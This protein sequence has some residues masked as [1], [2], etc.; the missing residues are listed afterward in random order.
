MMEL[1]FLEIQSNQVPECDTLMSRTTCIHA[2][3]TRKGYSHC[4][5]RGQCQKLQLINGATPSVS[6]LLPGAH[7]H[8]P[9][10]RRIS[11]PSAV[12]PCSFTTSCLSST[13]ELGLTATNEHRADSMLASHTQRSKI[14]QFHRER[15][16]VARPVAAVCQISRLQSNADGRSKIN[17][18]R[19]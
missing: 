9:S 7:L 10:R 8:S 18:N 4:G 13:T 17:Q 14:L 2:I 15:H 11:C 3:L 16:P 1:N 6:A 19:F 12:H 5:Q